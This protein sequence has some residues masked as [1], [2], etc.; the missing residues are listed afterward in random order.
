LI[1]TKHLSKNPKH[2]RQQVSQVIAARQLE[3]EGVDIHAGN[4]IRFV[5]TCSENKYDDRRV[6]AEQL[7]ERGVNADEKKYLR[8]L[9]DSV[10]NLLGFKGYT[11]KTVFDAVNGNSTTNLTRFLEQ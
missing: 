6:K 8:L 10:V 11:I 4:N 7:I 2:Y 3:K 1:I 9:Y 5:F